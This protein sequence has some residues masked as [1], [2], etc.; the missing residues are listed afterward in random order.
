MLAVSYMFMHIAEEIDLLCV[1]I[2]C[3]G[4]QLEI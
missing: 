2:I 3:S 1:C 4:Q